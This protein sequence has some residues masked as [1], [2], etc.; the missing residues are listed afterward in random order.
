MG[1]IKKKK[2]SYAQNAVS[3]THGRG[4]ENKTSALSSPWSKV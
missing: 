1:Q 2:F 3:V 4:L